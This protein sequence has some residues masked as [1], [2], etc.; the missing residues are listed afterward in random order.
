MAKQWDHQSG[1]RERLALLAD[2]GPNLDPATWGYH[3]SR[4]FW[5]YCGGARERQGK[6]SAEVKQEG[7]A[8]L[9]LIS[10]RWNLNR[11]Q[12]MEFI[13]YPEAVR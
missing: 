8:S 6:V 1:V 10:E 11:V 9:A 12:A 2:I 5:Y 3:P 7:S 4:D 13:G